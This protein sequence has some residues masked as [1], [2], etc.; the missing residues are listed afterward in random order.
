LKK[1]TI[2][3]DGAPPDTPADP[4]YL[5]PY[6]DGKPAAYPAALKALPK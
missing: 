4:R 1:S 5:H 6:K 3:L 2:Y